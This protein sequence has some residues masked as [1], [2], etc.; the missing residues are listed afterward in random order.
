MY[1]GCEHVE[2]IKMLDLRLRPAT[3]SQT[4]LPMQ[5]RRGRK[6]GQTLTVRGAVSAR[7]EAHEGSVWRRDTLPAQD[8]GSAAQGS[9]G[10][11][12]GGRMAEG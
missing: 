9:W 6:R 11:D 1:A 2:Y 8:G 4:T 12:Q 10:G 7:A 3:S 5:K